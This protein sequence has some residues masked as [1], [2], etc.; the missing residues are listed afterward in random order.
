M[1]VEFR[2]LVLTGT[3]AAAGPSH[4][5]LS[6]DFRSGPL[7]KPSIGI[8]IETRVPPPDRREAEV[9]LVLA[10]SLAR[11]IQL[12]RRARE[13][14]VGK[15]ITLMR[16]YQQE[17]LIRQPLVVAGVGTVREVYRWHTP[18][19]IHATSVAGA[20]TSLLISTFGFD[21]NELPEVFQHVGRVD[22]LP[23]VVAR[24]DLEMK[25]RLAEVRRART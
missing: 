14:Q 9:E 25:T 8:R 13:K 16:D 19:V 23:E 5:A 20:G 3:S 11:S 22:E 17:I 21:T 7:E 1:V 6:L 2:G 24:Y 10:A 12:G 4:K 15:K 18:G